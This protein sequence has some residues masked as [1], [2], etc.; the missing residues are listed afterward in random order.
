MAEQWTGKLFAVISV[1]LLTPSCFIKNIFPFDIF[2]LLSWNSVLRISESC[3]IAK[4][5]GA[6]QDLL[7]FEET[8]DS[9]FAS[10]NTSVFKSV[11]LD[12]TLKKSQYLFIILEVTDDWIRWRTLEKKAFLLFLPKWEQINTQLFLPMWVGT[13]LGAS[14]KEKN[15]NNVETITLLPTQ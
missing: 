9:N 5:T 14:R 11:N 6:Y 10:A 2:V 8:I 13:C 3:T 12:I 7:F 1:S 4:Y 15:N